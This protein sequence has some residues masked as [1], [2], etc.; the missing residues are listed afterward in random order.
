[1]TLRPCT[2]HERAP[3]KKKSPFLMLISPSPN[4]H[5]T[6]SC[7][8]VQPQSIVT[9]DTSS[10][11]SSACSLGCRAVSFSRCRLR[12]ASSL[13]TPLTYVAATYVAR[14][15]CSSIRPLLQRTFVGL[16]RYALPPIAG[17]SCA[18]APCVT[19]SLN[20]CLSSIGVGRTAK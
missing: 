2:P 10:P 14:R 8:S 4:P 6:P 15:G 18:L 20:V 5:P 13:P 11:F 16:P 7:L 1:M 19:R 17:R 3:N 12:R 9:A